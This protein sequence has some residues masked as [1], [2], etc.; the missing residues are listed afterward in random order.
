MAKLFGGKHVEFETAP[1]EFKKVPAAEATAK[2][3]TVTMSFRR[4]SK[5]DPADK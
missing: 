5:R 4:E 2:L 1:W 3:K